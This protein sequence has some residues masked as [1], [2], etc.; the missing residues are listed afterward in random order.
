LALLASSENS[1]LPNRQMRSLIAELI[2]EAPAQPPLWAR[3]ATARRQTLGMAN[4]NYPFGVKEV[5]SRMV[6]YM[7]V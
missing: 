7:N 1:F 2:A 3:A 6:L 5:S 4:D